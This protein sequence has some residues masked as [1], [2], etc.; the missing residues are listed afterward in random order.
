MLWRRLA[1]LFPLCILL[2]PAS[3]SLGFRLRPPVIGAVTGAEAEVLVTGGV[4]YLAADPAENGMGAYSYADRGKFLGIARSGE[5]TLRVYAV[6]GDEEE[7]LRYV[8]W[9]WEGRFYIR[10][11]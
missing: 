4:R 1:V 8:L 7:R 9:E 2:V 6:K 5:R 10:A 11:E 3:L